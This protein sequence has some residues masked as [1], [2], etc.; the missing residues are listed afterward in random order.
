[1]LG[2]IAFIVTASVV[3]LYCTDLHDPAS[4]GIGLAPD[5]EE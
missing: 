1:M 5:Y 3:I 4:V 2:K